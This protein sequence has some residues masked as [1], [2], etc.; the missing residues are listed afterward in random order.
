MAGAMDGLT[1]EQQKLS[2]QQEVVGN[3]LAQIKRRW[4]SLHGPLL[5]RN[6]PS[7]SAGTFSPS[8]TTACGPACE[9]TWR[10]PPD[11]R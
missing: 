8:S 5:E 4:R 2:A 3:W 7:C 10:P 1:E 9:P 11:P 6:A